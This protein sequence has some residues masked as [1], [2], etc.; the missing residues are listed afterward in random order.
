MASID[1][2]Y[3]NKK[4]YLQLK[5]F[6]RKHKDYSNFV[7]YRM[8]GFYKYYR[9]NK[10][11]GEFPICNLPCIGDYWLAKNCKF[12]WLQQKIRKMYGATNVSQK[13]FMYILEIAYRDEMIRDFYNQVEDLLIDVEPLMKRYKA[14]KNIK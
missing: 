1:K 11:K 4:Q 13:E 7:G 9:I 8:W 12:K 10:M 2:I 14:V 5:E 6:V 3:G